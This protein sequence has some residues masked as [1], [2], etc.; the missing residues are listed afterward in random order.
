MEEIKGIKDYTAIVRRRFHWLVWPAMAIFLAA[1]TVALFLPNVFK[2]EAII[3]IEGKQVTDALVPT[4]VTSY[5]DQRIQSISQQVMSRSKILDL[6]KKFNLYPNARKNITTDALVEMVKDSIGISPISAE[7]KS[8]RSNQPSLLTIAFQLSFEDKDPVKAQQVTNALASFYLAQNL[9]ARQESAKGTTEFL[10]KQVEKTKETSATLEHELADFKKAHLEELPEFM[11]LN[12]QKIEKTNNDL[13]NASREIVSLREQ[14]IAVRNQLSALNPYEG[15]KNSRVL[16]N[17]EQLQQLELKRAQLLAKYSPEHPTVK[18]LEKE[19]SILKEGGD[20]S[21]DVEEKRERL[22]ELEQELA[23]LQAKY[24]DKHPTIKKTKAEIAQIKKDIAAAEKNVASVNDKAREA[25][26]PAYITMKSELDRI[27]IRLKSLE[28]EKKRLTQDRKAIYAKL[29]TMPEVER[30][31]RELNLE[32]EN[33]KDNLIE[34]QRKLQVAVIAEGMEEGRLGEKFTMI[35]PPYLPEEPYKPNRPAILII[36][37]ILGL[38]CGIGSAAVKEFNDNSIR[39]PESIQKLT[40]YDILTVIPRIQTPAEIKK[41][42]RKTLLL[43]IILLA[44]PILLL[45]VIHF[46]VMDLY[47]VYEKIVRFLG[48][49]FMFHF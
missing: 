25:T 21:K 36:G 37:L 14:E 20:Y 35:E 4:T 23:K 2:S 28:E 45:G 44:T 27:V 16:T 5:A 43:I 13:S 11:Q 32:Y 15:D 48:E 34:L 22:T 42:H 46:F 9:E 3:L 47:I 26:N 10:E 33:A 24:S 41:K 39:G 12:V 40:N 29:R 49:R 17:S 8:P 18:A 1:A 7:I 30:K 31:Y 38:G 6:V 19:I